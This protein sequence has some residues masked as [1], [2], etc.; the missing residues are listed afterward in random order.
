MKKIII[1]LAFSS[2][3]YAQENDFPK[4]GQILGHKGG[5]FFQLNENAIYYNNLET[6]KANCDGS[7]FLQNSGQLRN[8]YQCIDLDEVYGLIRPVEKLS[9]E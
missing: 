3:V 5:I 6:C 4:C 1:I 2:L 8:W 7:C 9:F